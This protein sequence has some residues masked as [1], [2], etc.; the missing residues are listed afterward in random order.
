[1]PYVWIDDADVLED[2]STHDLKRELA[3][4][5]AEDYASDGDAESMLRD[6]AEQLDTAQDPGFTYR[7]SVAATLRGLAGTISDKP[8]SKT[9]S[10]LA[11]RLW[12]KEMRKAH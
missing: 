1:M 10:E 11:Y 4:R 7:A 6:I 2:I 12:Q 8:E 5:L 9:K 3:K